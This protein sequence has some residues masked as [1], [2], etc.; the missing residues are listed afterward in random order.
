MCASSQK[1]SGFTRPHA[2][3]DI[4]PGEVEHAPETDSQELTDGTTR[5]ELFYLLKNQR[6]RFI[7]HHLKNVER[8]IEIGELA[9]QVAAWENKVACEDVTSKQRRRVY[10][11]L[12]QTHV[13][14]LEEA[15][16]ISV[17]RRSVALT[18]DAKQLD[19][20]LDLVP[21]ADVPWSKYYLALGGI[22]TVVTTA[23]WLDA[24]LFSLLSNFAVGTFVSIAFLMSAVAH[25]YYQQE[26][27]IGK[28]G[29][30][31][32]LREQ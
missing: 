3:D 16:M 18:E 2:E 11:A 25:Y 15:G 17:E 30:P 24:S 7:L 31:P 29:K 13:P 10:N 27:R 4:E 21:G 19:I 6:R 20:Y 22:G 9:R 12:Q 32:E 26:S 8:P 23:T 5:D 14:K 1:Q 28:S